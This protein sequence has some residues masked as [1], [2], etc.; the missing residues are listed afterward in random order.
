MAMNTGK[1]K[2]AIGVVLAGVILV[3][4]WIVSSNYWLNLAN[5]AISLSVVCLGLNILLG[6][7]GQIC[8]AQA[9]FWGIGA[10]TSALLTTKLGCPVWIGMF[11]S[12]FVAALFGVLL[13]IPSLK[14]SGHYLAVVTI[15]FGFIV[16]LLMIN[17]ISLTNGADGITQIPSPSICGFVF[18]THAKFFYL[19]AVLLVL[20]TIACIRLKNSRVGRALFAIRQNEMA[21]ETSGIHTTY[22]K[23][24]AFA[25]SSG[26]A[27]FGGSLFA[28]SGAHYISPDTFSFDQSVMLLA[29]AVLGGDG[30]AVGA[31][32]GA[33]LLSLLPE[34]LRF[35][36]DS[37]MMV[38]AAGIV[39]IMIFMPGGIANL[40]GGM[41]SA[42][43]LRNWWSARISPESPTLAAAPGNETDS[44]HLV[45]EAH[46][47]PP[48]ESDSD[49]VL[50]SVRCLAKH[51]GGLKAVDGVDMT[52]GRGEIHA[53]IGP[54]GS[55]KTTTINMLSGLYVPSAGEIQF[56]GR[57]LAGLSPHA[58]TAAGI[59]RTFQNIRLFGTLT[60]LDN[61]MIGGHVHSKSGV[62]AGMIHSPAQKKE[63]RDLR[64]RAFESLRFVGLSDR[65]SGLAKSLPYGQQRLLEIARALASGPKLL[66]LDEP[67]AGL[68]PAETERMT[69]L[70]YRIREQ[71]ITILLVEHDMNLVMSISDQ[72]TVLNFGKKI[73]EGTNEQ[74]EVHPEVIS[75]YLGKEVSYA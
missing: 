31:I 12:F 14:L 65:W 39:L 69:E 36:K 22:Y 33:A 71:A 40:V 67:A 10:Y 11:S 56:L 5:M 60:V 49:G 4:P 29:M 25:L 38:Y 9:A 53:L 46:L 64:E 6:Y 41:A 68:N 8:L 74:I 58:I 63:E 72:I 54:N 44:G 3:F 62:L 55:G 20:L 13:G 45:K 16:Q 27:G 21:A 17:W 73:A 1:E 35:L 51:F 75:A 48:A 42:R 47:T 66:L 32:V 23:I 34:L 61:V 43:R 15:G 26:Y 30:S 50:L 18:D 7:T 52:I 70:L 2:I 57:D 59:A 28:H 19:A 37:Y 24:V